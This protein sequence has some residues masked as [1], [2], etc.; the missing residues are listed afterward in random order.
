[1]PSQMTVSSMTRS[2]NSP[3]FESDDAL[4]RSVEPPELWLVRLFGALV[5]HLLLL[6][7]VRSAWVQVSVP[8]GGEG[9]TIEFVEVGAVESETAIDPSAKAEGVAPLQNLKPGQI[10]SDPDQTMIVAQPTNALPSP[11]PSVVEPAPQPIE[12]SPTTASSP[13]PKATASPSP[14]ATASPGRI[15]N[16]PNLAI[17][18]ASNLVSA[19]Q[20]SANIRQAGKAKLLRSEFPN[21]TT[22]TVGIP[23]GTRLTVYVYV[24]INQPPQGQGTVEFLNASGTQRADSASETDENQQPSSPKVLANSP[25]LATVKLDQL[26]SMVKQIL[27]P[28]IFTISKPE[29]TDSTNPQLYTQYTEWTLELE[30][31]AL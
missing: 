30:I 27:E 3:Q 4:R 5:L 2:V 6:A 8:K 31:T 9:G 11:S 22:K 21:L 7:G 1:M 17:R 15:P 29:T 16:N 26:Q 14:K 25:A 20:D 19:N 12:P 10:T 23:S 24:V 28:A 18:I 13:S